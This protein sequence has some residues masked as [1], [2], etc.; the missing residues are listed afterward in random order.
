M[1]FAQIFV[2]FN[3][4]NRDTVFPHIVFALEWFPLLNLCTA[5]F[6]LMYCELWISKFK[7]EE[8][9]LKLYEEIRYFDNFDF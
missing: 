5:T 8:F 6:G 4:K 3:K 9:P 1:D 7:K 2:D